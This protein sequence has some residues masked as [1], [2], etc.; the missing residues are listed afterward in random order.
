[1]G[2]PSL[3]S[4][5]P[6]W[7]SWDPALEVSSTQLHG[8]APLSILD[9]SSCGKLGSCGGERVL[10]F[11]SLWGRGWVSRFLCLLL[12]TWPEFL[13][14]SQGGIFGA[15]GKGG[16]LACLLEMR[17]PELRSLYLEDE[18]EWANHI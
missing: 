6:G 5:T 4:P 11:Y 16:S 13:S 15:P 1:M 12:S 17:Y 10:G 3:L 2:G 18:V 9:F 14:H 7:K 8:S